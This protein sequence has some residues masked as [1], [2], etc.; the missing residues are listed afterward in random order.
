MGKSYIDPKFPFSSSGLDHLG[1]FDPPTLTQNDGHTAPLPHHGSHPNPL[2]SGSS[3]TLYLE[4]RMEK[5]RLK[6][7]LFAGD[8]TGPIDPTKARMRAKLEQRR[9]QK[10]KTKTQKFESQTK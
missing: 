7:I 10:M 8:D 2:K 6:Q 9:R 4:A 1:I 5:H 3:K